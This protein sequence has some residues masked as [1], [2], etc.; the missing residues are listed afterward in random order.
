MA[1]IRF[2]TTAIT[3]AEILTA[4][5][6]VFFASFAIIQGEIDRRSVEIMSLIA[7]D[8]KKSLE[9]YTEGIERSVEVASNLA[10]DNLDGVLLVKSVNGTPEQREELDAYLASYT[11]GVQEVFAT[12]VGQTRGAITYYYC[13]SPEVSA[14]EH[15]FYYSRVGRVGYDAREPIDARELDPEDV[16]HTTW[17]YTPIRR[18]RPSWVGPYTAKTLDEMV[19]DSFLVPVYKSGIFIGVLGMDIPLD[20]L[21]SLVSSIHVYDTGFACLLDSEN[22]VL[23]HPSIQAGTQ[24]DLQVDPELFDRQDSGDSL[25]RYVVDGQERQISFTTL[26]CGMKLVIVAPTS[27]VNA[28]ARRLVTTIPPIAV[29]VVGVFTVLA[30][31]L[32]RHITQPLQRLTAASHRLA[33]ADYEVELDYKGNDEVGA[34][35]ASFEVM[36]DQ[37]K[38]HIDDLSLRV[39]TDDMT[40]LANQ[41]HFFDIAVV[42]RD[43]LLSEG[44]LPVIVYFNLMGMKHYNR[45]FGFDEGDRLIC[46]FAEILA[47][48]FGRE[49]LA[50]FSQDHFAVVTEEEGLDERLERV[51]DACRDANGGRSLPVSAGIYRNGIEDVTVSVACDRAKYACDT[52]RGSYVSGFCYF[53][54]DMHRRVELIRHVIGHLDQAIAE[55][56]VKVYYQ[57]IV[58]AVN[59][60]V[61]DEEALSRWIDPERGFLSPADFIPALEDAGLIY[62]LDLYVLEKA[63]KKMRMQDEYG[64]TVVPHSINL[65]RSD[66]DACDMVEEIRRRVDAS[67]FSR[68]M[69]TIEITESIIGSD[70]DFM[71]EQVE[72]FQALGFPVWMDDFGSGYSSLDFLQLIKFDLLKFDMSFMRRLDEGENGKIILTEL[73]QMATALGVDTICEGVETADQVRFLQRIGCSKLQ[74][75]YYSKPIPLADIVERYRTGTQIGYENPDEAGYFEAIGKVNLYDLAAVAAGEGDSLLNIFNTLPMGIAEVTAD[76]MGFVRANESFRDFMGRYFAND[77]VD[78]EFMV[79]LRDCG[80]GGGRAVFEQRLHDGAVAHFMVRRVKVNEVTGAAAVA[81][82]VISIGAPDEGATYASIARALSVDY[83]N[84][85]Y[86]DLDTGQ[87]TEY[88]SPVG[89]QELSV[90]RHGEDFFGEAR[91]D[92]RL[93]IHEEDLEAFLGR[94]TRDNVVR[95]LD[96]SGAFLATYRLIDN[97]TTMLA[98]MKVS[99]MEPDGHHIIIG[100]SVKDASTA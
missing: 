1:S 21:T 42:E 55:G 40:G 99:R 70:F 98:S 67:G 47:G 31:L 9:K 81:I 65:S 83:Y 92:A 2:K 88:S 23:Y 4:I 34:L 49:L 79:R 11:A 60:R 51:F 84:I 43:R 12:V 89:G 52:R 86:V 30:F 50:R 87:F 58:R 56:W 20:T 61:C 76:G 64:L 91:I 16:A 26:S 24:P 37:L 27:E 41:R 35:T 78:S 44:R 80:E 69:I 100:I 14:V 75:Y 46:A 6:C 90:E 45:Q 38:R 85:Y 97:G 13:I 10:T 74:G 53:D 19:I 28:A 63:L 22:R 32:M 77:L 15:G 68:D 25:I 96:E 62:K 48:E 17:Y 66:F 72:R 71:K 36:R 8:T 82:A 3:I 5:A 39:I 93:R 57:P 95:E 29:A 94:F 54:I 7:Q 33:A 59:G 73:M 18:G